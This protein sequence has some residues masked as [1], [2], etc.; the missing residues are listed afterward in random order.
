[1]GNKTENVCLLT[2]INLI[3]L[4]W[5]TPEGEVFITVVKMI[6]RKHKVRKIWEEVSNC[7]KNGITCCQK[8]DTS[9]TNDIQSVP[10]SQSWN[11]YWPHELHLDKKMITQNWLEIFSKCLQKPGCTFLWF[12][13]CLCN[14]GNSAKHSSPHKH[15]THPLALL[16]EQQGPKR[17]EIK[18]RVTALQSNFSWAHR[19]LCARIPVLY[20]VCLQMGSAALSLTGEEP[21]KRFLNSNC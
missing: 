8:T 5:M 4:L 3:E 6:I 13:T 9:E 15:P 10:V 11:Y 1:M 14:V 20:W 18:T 16:R 21:V 19:A 7:S 2:C 17:M 12:S